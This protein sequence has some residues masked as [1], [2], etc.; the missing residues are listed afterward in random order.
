MIDRTFDQATTGYLSVVIILNRRVPLT[1]PFDG[2]IR[3][4]G[5]ADLSQLWDLAWLNHCC[6]AGD[7]SRWP[8][9]CCVVFGGL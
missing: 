2:S 3:C 1:D 7:S 6:V 9:A 8:W 5:L 4:D